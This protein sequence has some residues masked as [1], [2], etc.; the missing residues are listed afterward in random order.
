MFSSR[1]PLLRG[2]AEGIR[3]AIGPLEE[4]VAG[5]SSARAIDAS[6]P[7]ARAVAVRRMH[8]VVARG[9]GTDGG[10]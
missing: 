8:A 1:K 6:M 5:P 9:C 4:S 7:S 3:E 2:S 10:M